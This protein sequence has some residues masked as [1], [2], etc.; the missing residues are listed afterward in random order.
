MLLH[1]E[2]QGEV[3]VL[4]STLLS[5]ALP[6]VIILSFTNLPPL[7]SAG[8][9]TLFAGG[10]FACLLTLKREWPFLLRCTAWRDILLATFFIGIA[11]YGCYFLGLKYTTAGNAAILSTTEVFFSFLI[12]GLLLRHEPLLPRTVAGA[13]CMVCGALLI[14]LPKGTGAWQ[15]GNLLILLSAALAPFGNRY[16][17][18][19]RK[20]VSTNV[21]MFCRSI[22]SGGC[23]LLLALTFEQTPTHEAVFA[24]LA[25]LLANG[26]LLLGLS[27]SLWVEAIHLIPITKAV[28]MVSILPLCTLLVAWLVLHETPSVLQIASL[29]PIAAGMFLLTKPARTPPLPAPLPQG[30]GRPHGMEKVSLEKGQ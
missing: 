7:F 11:G 25:F 27:V 17:Q 28:A 9:S 4:L 21:I 19:A 23:L 30:E 6:V 15:W 18:R 22:I 26:F 29:L 12:L 2:R 5:S 14:L 1:Q 20:V 8:M 13:V 3:N 10:F 24:S 16:A